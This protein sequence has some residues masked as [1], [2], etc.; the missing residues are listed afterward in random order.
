MYASMGDSEG[1]TKP[2][3]AVNCSKGAQPY[4]PKQ[5]SQEIAVVAV[6]AVVVSSSK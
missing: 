1:V 6:V 3:S 2:Q 4:K 5:L